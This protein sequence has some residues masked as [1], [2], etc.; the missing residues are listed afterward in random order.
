MRK[1]KKK[2]WNTIQMNEAIKI[3]IL[4]ITNMKIQ[5]NNFRDLLTKSLGFVRKTDEVH[6]ILYRYYENIEAKLFVTL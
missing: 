2:V 4:R 5:V 6:D 3:I 1:V